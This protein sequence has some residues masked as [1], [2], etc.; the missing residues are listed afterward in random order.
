MRILITA[1]GRPS[2]NTANGVDLENY[3][4]P[5]VLASRGHSVMFAC[6]SSKEALPIPG[7]EVRVY[8]PNLLGFGMSNALKTDLLSWQPDVAVITS[9]YT[10]FN[11]R[12]AAWLRH[13]GVP[14]VVKPNGGYGRFNETLGRWKKR[15]YKV[16][17]EMPMLD[18]ALFL[19]ASGDQD[20]I[21]RY[22]SRTP[23]VETTRGVEIEP[24]LSGEGSLDCLKGLENSFL[25][26]YL[27]RLDPIH[28]GLDLALAAFDRLNDEKAAF[29]LAGP[30]DGT[31]AR[32]LVKLAGGLPSAPRIRF[33]GGLY[34]PDRDDFLRAIDVFVHPS[35]WEGGVPNSVAKAAAMAKPLLI[36]QYADPSDLLYS[37]HA[38]VRAELT[39]ESVADGM[40]SLAGMSTEDRAAIGTRAASAVQSEFGW[41]KMVDGFLEGLRFHGVE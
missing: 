1:V 7:A 11:N 16:L 17:L 3:R 38:C 21:R 25:Y 14:Y 4:M 24:E 39:V 37:R 35:R 34:G 26:G 33:V 40:S 13:H 6:I 20:D 32:K 2:P 30:T 29:V 36:T 41:E 31:S 28:K 9:V 8:P 23:L 12:I 15:P 18:Q 19:W 5:G 27:G 22:G 10:P